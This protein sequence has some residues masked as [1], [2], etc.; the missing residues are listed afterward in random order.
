MRSREVA[1]LVR[2][3]FTAPRRRTHSS[4]QHP[5]DSREGQGADQRRRR[6][7][8]RQKSSWYQEFMTTISIAALSDQELLANTER[9]AGHERQITANLLAL[10]GEIDARRLYL[11]EGTGRPGE[12]R[13]AVPSAQCVRGRAD[14]WLGGGADSV[15]D[16]V[17]ARAEPLAEEMDL[18][19]PTSFL[20]LEGLLHLRLLA[21]HHVAQPFP[22]HRAHHSDCEDPRPKQNL[23]GVRHGQR[24]LEFLKCKITGPRKWRRRRRYDRWQPGNRRRLR[25][26]AGSRRE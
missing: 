22:P 5:D 14:L 15:Q 16:R 9:S 21:P 25:P 2:M 4:N 10:L 3:A 20:L 26:A 12:H 7:A 23:F 24:R 8:T 18:T 1:A 6:L 13:V 19:P 17:G 11:G